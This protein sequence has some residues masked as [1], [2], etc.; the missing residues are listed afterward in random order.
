MYSEETNSI[1]VKSYTCS[2]LG[3]ESQ[4]FFEFCKF[5]LYPS[6][7]FSSVFKLEIRSGIPDH[8][9]SS[10][11]EKD[12]EALQL[13][14]Q[15]RMLS[16]LFTKNIPPIPTQDERKPYPAKSTNILSKV[17]F[18]W[19]HP[20]LRTGYSRTLV[21]EDL[22]TLTEE[23]KVE[24]LAS[25]FLDHFHTGIAQAKAVHV[26]LK[27]VERAETAETSTVSI[28]EDLEDFELERKVIVL[29]LFKTFK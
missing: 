10:L 27:H 26:D 25:I 8:T 1:K 16:W 9:M 21:P 14:R 4:I 29:A 5:K 13:E 23:T 20:V 28:D 12:H 11:S 2:H 6:R 15:D 7:G 17:F 19:L 22:F 24:N 18:W 3:F